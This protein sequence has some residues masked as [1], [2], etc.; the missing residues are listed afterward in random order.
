MEQQRTKVD[1]IIEYLGKKEPEIKRLIAI[2]KKIRAF[3]ELAKKEEEYTG[4]GMDI[5]LLAEWK[6]LLDKYYPMA[7]KERLK[8]N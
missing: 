4:P 8:K 7:E 5:T 3:A 2:D 1:I 6:M